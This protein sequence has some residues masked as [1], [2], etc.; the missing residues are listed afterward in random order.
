MLPIVGTHATRGSLTRRRRSSA[1]VFMTSM[2][3]SYE[4]DRN[5]TSNA[6]TQKTQGARTESSNDVPMGTQSEP[7]PTCKPKFD[8]FCDLCV[9]RAFALGFGF[10][11]PQIEKLARTPHSVDALQQ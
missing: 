9:F 3:R 8:F 5:R 1:I 6:K 2:W 7:S 11:S 4:H 10:R